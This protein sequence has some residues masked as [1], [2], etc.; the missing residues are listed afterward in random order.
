[1]SKVLFIY[2]LSGND[3][4]GAAGRAHKP[5]FESLGHEFV[6]IDFSNPPVGNER[7]GRML[8]EPDIA[9]AYSGMGMAAGLTAKSPDGRELNLWEAFHIPFLS[10]IGDSPS[11]FFDRHVAASRWNALLYYYPEHL[12]LRQRLLPKGALYGIVPPMPFDMADRAEIDFARKERG[13]LLFLKN[14]NDPERLIASWQASMPAE[15]FLLLTDLARDLSDGMTG[16]VGDDIDGLVTSSFR[17]RGWDITEFANLRLYFVAQLDDYL[18]RIKSML[19]ADVLADFPV[20]IQGNNWEHMDFTRRRATYVKG[21]DY[22]RSRQQIVDALGLV[23]MSPNTQRAPHDRPMRAFGL[24]TLCLTNRQAFFDAH[25]ARASEFTFRFDR[26]ELA[27]MVADVL[28]HPARYV[29][30]GAA[31]AEE[32]RK[33]RHPIQ[34]AEYLLATANHVRLA[35]GPRPHGLQDYF[36]WPPSRFV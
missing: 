2:G 7:L 15:T 13:T 30:L 29:E 31:V 10:L 32:F 36:I 14:G 20:Q 18:R 16:P 27:A 35:C 17:A 34:F 33:D 11:Y 1:M 3:A 9:F 19:L 21:G 28:A 8:K 25:A 4:L 23:D 12:E 24:W 26:E 5:L 6:E 22:T